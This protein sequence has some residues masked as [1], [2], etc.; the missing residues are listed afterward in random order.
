MEDY[1]GN[2]EDSCGSRVNRATKL[3]DNER[4]GL[5]FRWRLTGAANKPPCGAWVKSPGIE[6]TGKRWRKPSGMDNGDE[7][8]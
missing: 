3:P 1:F 4:V 7:R 6:R 8:K 5:A 2:N